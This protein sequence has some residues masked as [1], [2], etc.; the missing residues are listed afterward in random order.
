VCWCFGWTLWRYGQ[1]T[2]L[3]IQRFEFSIGFGLLL[4]YPLFIITVPL[5]LA[6]A[7]GIGSGACPVPC[8]KPFS[9]S[10]CEGEAW[11]LL[12]LLWDWESGSGGPVAVTA[13]VT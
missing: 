11:L 12:V 4:Y 2:A 10:G 7:A 1:N 9:V 8:G 13:K 3:M 6:L 5:R